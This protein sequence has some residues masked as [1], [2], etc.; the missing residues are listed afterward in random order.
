MMRHIIYIYAVCLLF[1]SCGNGRQTVSFEEGDTV[2]FR[3]AGLIEAVRYDRCTVVRMADP[4]NAGRTLHTYVLVPRSAGK[5]EGLPEGTVI[6]TPLHRAVS[7]S[8]VHAA[9]AINL[10]RQKSIVGMADIQY[11]KLPY[12]QQERRAG[13]I[14]DVG[15][16]LNPDIERL[17]DARPDAVLV[18]P[19]ENSGGYGKLEETGIPIIECPDYMEATALGRAEWMRFFGMLFGAEDEA[20][21]LFAVVDSCYQSLRFKAALSSTCR[22]VLVDKMTGSVWYMPGGQSTFGTMLA[23]AGF[24]YAFSDDSHSGSLALPFETVLDECGDADV[25][26][27]RHSYRRPV[28][29]AELFSEYHG[30]GR[31]RPFRERQCYGC[32]VETSLFFEETPFRPDYLLADL[33][34][35]AHPEISIPGEMRYFQKVTE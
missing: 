10:R 17:I 32:N 33:I 30:Y 22:R 25:W 26:L 16:S 7:F 34:R 24:A 14:V 35:I 27:F 3:Y 9:L 15:S 18:S 20:D 4:W 21:S 1:L 12:V 8:T 31:L 23:D 5:V 29:Y 19:F 11:A 6:R 28:T 2:A 13:R